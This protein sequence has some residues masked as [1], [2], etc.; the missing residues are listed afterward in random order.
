MYVYIYIDHKRFTKY[1][2]AKKWKR[3]IQAQFMPVFNG[4]GAIV[5]SFYSAEIQLVWTIEI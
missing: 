5:S 4:H 1:V 3:V 2:L